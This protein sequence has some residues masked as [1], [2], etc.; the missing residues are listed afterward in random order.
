LPNLPFSGFVC[1]SQNNFAKMV[2]LPSV[3][4]YIAIHTT[5]KNSWNLQIMQRSCI[6]LFAGCLPSG[7]AE[8]ED[9]SPR[10]QW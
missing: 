10:L 9:D 2:G 8:E 1:H 3:L 6:F 5:G 7:R 4:N